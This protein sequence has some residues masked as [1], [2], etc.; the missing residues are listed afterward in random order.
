M[1]RLVLFKTLKFPCL[2]PSEIYI[3]KHLTS[4]H[5]LT[6]LELNHDYERID[7]QLKYLH[8]LTSLTSYNRQKNLHK[9]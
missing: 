8:Y 1:G 2:C 3:R 6:L 5:V 7:G 4:W 9:E